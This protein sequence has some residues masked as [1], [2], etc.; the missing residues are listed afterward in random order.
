MASSEVGLGTADTMRGAI[1]DAINTSTTSVFSVMAN[2]EVVPGTPQDHPDPEPI[3]GVVALLGFTG[4]WVGTGMFY[5]KEK[6][7]CRLGA[8]MLMTEVEDVNSD[9][10]DGVGE[11]ANMVLGN[12][13]EAMESH[14]GPLSLSLPTVVYGRNFSTRT[15]V[16]T[17]WTI[18]PFRAGDDAFEVRVC[19]KPKS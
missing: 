5:C 1:I 12:F 8:A 9:V 10:L 17:K 4:G 13:K 7:A 15:A 3:D 11:M 6:F 14:L 18:V 19:I 2:L 16:R